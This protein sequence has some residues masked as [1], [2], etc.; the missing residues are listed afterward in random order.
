[1]KIDF[2]VVYVSHPSQQGMVFHRVIQG[3]QLRD[4]YHLIIAPNAIHGILITAA[5]RELTSLTQE[6]NALAQE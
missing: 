5:G 1:M 3:L 2:L 4:I 6:I